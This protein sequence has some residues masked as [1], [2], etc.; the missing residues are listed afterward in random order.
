[1]FFGAR[2][3]F[4]VKNKK[5]DSPYFKEAREVKGIKVAFFS[6]KA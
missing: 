6:G 4:F 2:G 3:I 5:G 1:L